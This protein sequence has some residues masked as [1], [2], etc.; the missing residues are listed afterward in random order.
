MVIPYIVAAINPDQTFYGYGIGK[1]TQTTFTGN[2]MFGAPS[3]FL[4][5]PV[6]GRFSGFSGILWDGSIV[7]ATCS[8]GKVW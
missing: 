5:D 3:S 6:T 7:N 4:R 1:V 8:C 2:T